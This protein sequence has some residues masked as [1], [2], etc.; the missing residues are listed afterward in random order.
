MPIQQSLGSFDCTDP[1]YTTEDFQKAITANI[2]KT[3]GPDEVDLLYH[4]AWILKQ[5]ALIQTALIA[6]AQ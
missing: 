2:V 3:A 4:K 6:P 5:I 1:T